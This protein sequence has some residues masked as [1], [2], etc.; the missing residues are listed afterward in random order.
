MKIKITKKTKSILLGYIALLVLLYLIIYTLPKVTDA[1]ETTQ[2]LEPGTLTV[3]R[4]AE[5]FLVKDEAVVTAESTGTIEF[6]IDE[7]TVVKK[8][9][10]LV[11]IEE[12]SS[13]NGENK[14]V[15]GRY[16][17]YLNNLINYEKLSSGTEAPISGVYS[18]HIDGGEKYF[19][20]GN[21]DNI[22]KEK[23]GEINIKDLNLYRTAV[24]KGEPVF[25]ISADDHWYIVC[26]MEPEDAR[27]YQEGLAVDLQLPAGSV[28]ATVASNAREKTSGAPGNR[29]VFYLNAYY[30]EFS[31]ARKV[32]MT[33]VIS[34][35]AGLIVDNECITEED[36]VAGVYVVTKNNEY[37]FKPIK[38]K[39]TDGKQS[40][41]YDGTFNNDKYEQVTTVNVY[42]EVV[43]NPNEKH[44]NKDENNEKTEG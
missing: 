26:W 10:R 34:N 33:I 14:T 18:R 42:D 36:G 21:L 19:N 39:A 25:K 44:K 41:I 8:G 31:T 30:E 32:D 3:S 13:E 29:V 12:T 17:P 22:R 24:V 40:V 15:R 7:G 9:T 37:L 23:A 16:K 38:V 1:F 20:T 4:N 43:K 35:N 11:E 6:L 2:V 28:K 5:G 27:P